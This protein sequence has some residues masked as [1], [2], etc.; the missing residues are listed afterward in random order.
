MVETNKTN[1]LCAGWWVLCEGHVGALRLQRSQF[2]RRVVSM[3]NWGK[4]GSTVAEE[5]G[6]NISDQG[7]RNVLGQ[8]REVGTHPC[9]CAGEQSS[10]RWCGKIRKDPD[11]NICMGTMES[12]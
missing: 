11:R 6:K 5:L 4:L 1:H 8:D 3:E 10:C 2:P 9:A 12:L 7:D